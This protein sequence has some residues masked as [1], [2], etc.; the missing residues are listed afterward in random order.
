MSFGGRAHTATEEPVQGRVSVQAR[1]RGGVGCERRGRLLDGFAARRWRGELP[2]H[3]QHRECSS[4]LLFPC[5]RSLV[6]ALVSHRLTVAAAAPFSIPPALAALRARLLPSPD[7]HLRA[8][9]RDLHQDIDLPRRRRVGLE[10]EPEPVGCG[11]PVPFTA[12]VGVAGQRDEP[13]RAGCGCG[14][15]E[16]GTEPGTRGRGVQGRRATQG[17]S[18]P[19]LPLSLAAL[20]PLTTLPDTPPPAETRRAPVE[21][22][23]LA[24]A[25]GDQGRAGLA[26]RRRAPRPAR[27]TAAASGARGGRGDRWEGS[28]GRVV[29]LFARQSRLVLARGEPRGGTASSV[30]PLSLP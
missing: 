4:S 15:W 20:P 10:P 25:A 12:G 14:C 29:V 3:S 27:M 18:C 30:A 1:R 5:S 19:A 21:R 7:H 6:D 9:H 26:Q 16:R 2:L 11:G 13:C 23:R 8:P 17:A 22:D 28:N 24:R